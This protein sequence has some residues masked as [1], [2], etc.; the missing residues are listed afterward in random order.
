MRHG[1]NLV[2][3]MILIVLMLSALLVTAS[4]AGSEKPVSTSP[5]GLDPGAY[6]FS[7][8][9]D[10]E[11][12]KLLEG[13]RKDEA[14]AA[15]DLAAFRQAEW[16]VD[17]ESL[18]LRVTFPEGY[19][20]SGVFSLKDDQT[21]MLRLMH[22]AEEDSLP[23]V[24]IPMPGDP[25]EIRDYEHGQLY[26]N[27]QM[28]FD[29]F[30]DEAYAVISADQEKYGWQDEW[31]LGVMC[32]DYGQKKVKLLSIATYHM[33]PDEPIFSLRQTWG[34]G[35]SPLYFPY[36]YVI[37][38]DD[39]NAGA[40]LSQYVIGNH[41]YYNTAWDWKDPS[42]VTVTFKCYLGEND[43][44]GD[45]AVFELKDDDIRQTVLREPT[46]LTDGEVECT[47]SVDFIDSTELK[48]VTYTSTKTLTI[49]ATG[50]PQRLTI[51]EQPKDAELRYPEGAT[52]R[53]AVDDPDFAVSY[54][55]YDTDDAGTPIKLDGL[56][57]TTPTLE[58][59]CTTMYDV[60]YDL[61]CVITDKNGN[62]TVSDTAHVTITNSL[63]HM[64]L[65]Y[66]GDRVV[67][68]GETLDL[69]TTGMGT[70]TVSF[71]A[72]GREVTLDSITVDLDKDH[73]LFD[74]VNSPC[75]GLFAACSGCIFE[76]SQF[77]VHVKGD[78]VVNSN[79][80]DQEK[81]SAGTCF[82][83]H[84]RASDVMTDTAMI[85][86]GD[87]TLLLNGGSNGIHTD[88]GLEINADLRTRSNGQHYMEGIY[89]KGD[90]SIGEGVSVDIQSF[91]PGFFV[92][93]VRNEDGTTTGHDISIGDGAAVRIDAT[94]PHVHSLSTELYGMVANGNMYLG[95]AD[96]DISLHAIKDT[97]KP[98]GGRISAMTG[99][100]AYNI[101][102]EGTDVSIRID[103]EKDGSRLYAGE[104]YGIQGES[105]QRLYLLEGAKADI[106]IDTPIVRD[107]AEGISSGWTL[108]DEEG[109]GLVL[110]DGSTLAVDVRSTGS[111]VF[112]VDI[113]NPVSVTDS[114][115][116]VNVEPLGGGMVFGV[117]C[118]DMDIDLNGDSDLVAVQ[119]KD[120]VAVFINDREDDATDYDPDYAPRLIRISGSAKITAPKDGVISRYG[121]PFNGNEIPGETVYDP[122]STDEPAQLVVISVKDL[123]VGHISPIH[124]NDFTDVDAAS[125]Y[126]DAVDYVVAKGL[127]DG[128]SSDRFDPN[129]TTTRS[130][131]VTIL[132]RLEGQPAV[133]GTNPFD[134]VTEGQW[135]TDAVIWA[136]EN[137]IVEGY[138]RGQ[139]GPS[140][141]I[142][143]EQF[144]SIL[145]RYASFKSWDIS[146]EADLSS[147]EDASSISSWA[148][149]AMKWANAEGLITGRTDTA[150]A[151]EGNTTRAEAAAILMR[152]IEA[153]S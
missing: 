65:F 45:T 136:N 28:V 61:F 129:G 98:Y 90:L 146:K 67:R 32:D 119:A 38:T 107:A 37:G 153:L 60:Y 87:G 112:G 56:T 104:A 115:M 71:D 80:Y 27:P 40:D 75:L 47:A 82:S 17:T 26:I 63:E 108:Q 22:L 39:E 152:A 72:A 137:G 103:A 42:H 148:E 4:A 105:L 99:M 46:E 59:P 3:G 9:D 110:E 23:W 122:A 143:R 135:Y 131:I 81:Y 58:L 145:Y 52:F 130:M 94:A 124:R 88:S 43:G 100:T 106:R 10:G 125:W 64:P 70:G 14:K 74:T 24:E 29:H 44:S 149:A 48:I 85:I 5:D 33:L 1:K 31:D 111:A 69:S 78:C 25:N 139:F 77:Y 126:H 19:D 36:D 117:S 30:F 11:L 133:S 102:L 120:G 151:P 86:D 62:K 123:P 95:K 79:Y 20:P 109:L 116:T 97:M 140:D 13:R 113:A 6:Y 150:L 73:L 7:M 134:D 53:V 144:A 118:S 127:M 96:V 147:Y 54:Q 57:A 84:F 12:F 16:F 15:E 101:V 8:E 138:G 76:D 18:E 92:D 141:T 51:T 2:F 121:F 89:A 21:F 50:D 142:T 114:E 93:S 55:W 83:G 41:D 91:G 66:V 128:V 34:E 35:D 49:P 68:P 132:Y